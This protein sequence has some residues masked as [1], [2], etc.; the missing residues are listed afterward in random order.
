MKSTM[1][2]YEFCIKNG[3]EVLL[4]LWDYEKND[5]KLD[6][7]SFRSKKEVYWK[8]SNNH[9]WKEGTDTLFL[10][11]GCP[12]C[13]HQRVSSEYNLEV[14]YPKLT[15]M[16]DYDRNI[17][18]LPSDVFPSS[19]KYYYWKCE[20]G[21]RFREKVFRLLRI[22]GCP[23]CSH[24]RVS[25]EY[26]F[27]VL[28][29][30]LLEEWDYEKNDILPDKCFPNSSKK[31]WWRCKI[32]PNHTWQASL[33][34]RA[35]K[36]GCPICKAEK[37][38]SFSEQAIF[39]YL[40]KVFSNCKNRYQLY[41]KEVDIYVPEINLAIEYDGIYR[42][43][44]SS[45]IKKDEE[46]EIFLRERKV[47]F[48][49]VRENPEQLEQ[50]FLNNNLITCKIDYKYSYVNE[51]IR[52]IFIYIDNRYGIKID[53]IIPDVEGD[54]IEI[55]EQYI[56]LVKENSI[57]IRNS[58]LLEEWDYEKNG[59]LDPSMISHASGKKF[60]WRCRDGH[61]FQMSA[62]HRSH[63]KGCPYCSGSKI[64]REN[65]LAIVNPKLAKLWDKDK[66]GGVSPF[67][68]SCKSSRKIW[69]R[70]DVGHSWQSEVRDSTTFSDCPYCNK[71]RVTDTNNF[72][73]L[74]P[75]LLEEWDYEKNDI[76]PYEISRASAKKV[77]WHCKNNHSFLVYKESAF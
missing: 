7:V 77:W 20:A 25:D 35:K 13:N 53:N 64:L 10:K 63:G 28:Y 51:V 29:P 5:I 16:W 40:R 9:S 66:N 62:L 23:Y 41:G 76:S 1:S 38:T 11:S 19:N 21:H 18:I 27:A 37:K 46:K 17:N 42:H 72:A 14:I 6:E 60:W 47:D 32:N 26:N 50:V 34:S 55:S 70:C 61:S 73:F 68:V 12:Y 74:C 33:I 31:V 15:S 67:D 59:R 56:T 58:Q 8:C 30:Y 69:W 49:R 44:N 24:E 3:K 36:T 71:R 39:Y 75:D 2:F 45:K 65:S 22:N 54:F 43:G 4:D 57:A 48:L 52:L